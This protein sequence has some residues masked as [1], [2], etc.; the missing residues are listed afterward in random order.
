MGNQIL[1]LLIEMKEEMTG[2][3]TEITDMKSGI[4]GIDS[5]VERVENKVDKNTVLIEN[6]SK[7]VKYIKG[8]IDVLEEIT[9]EHEIAI[10]KLKKQAI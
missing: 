10:R 8:S 2:I 1:Q 4:K 9:G 6:V 7:N 5:K 3:K